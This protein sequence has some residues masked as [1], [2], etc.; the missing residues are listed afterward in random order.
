MNGSVTCRIST[1]L[2]FSTCAFPL[3]CDSFLNK[4]LSDF[5]LA[6]DL[7]FL[8]KARKY[9]FFKP[10]FI[11]YATY[12]S[13]KIGY[14]RYITICRHLMKNPEYQVS[15][16]YTL[17]NDDGQYRQTIL[18]QQCVAAINLGFLSFLCS[19]SATPFFRSSRIG[20]RMRTAT[21]TS[22][23]PSSSAIPSFSLHG[24]RS[25]GLASFAFL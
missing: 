3:V 23:L 5:N 21:A 19:C 8:T 25:C 13:E 15:A 22:L 10:Q 9:T 7:G 1:D 6:L 24:P 16:S 12:L 4:A 11:F 2:T 18:D 17:K 20:A 14:W